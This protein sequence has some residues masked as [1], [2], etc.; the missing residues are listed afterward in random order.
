MDLFLIHDP[1]P[2][3]GELKAYWTQMEAI[4]REGLARSIGVSNFRVPDLEDILETATVVPAVNQVRSNFG[5]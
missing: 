2:A 3:R 5:R 4:K 1:T